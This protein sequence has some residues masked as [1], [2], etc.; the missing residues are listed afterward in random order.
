MK[1]YSTKLTVQKN[2]KEV[3]R[4]LKSLLL[5]Y[6]NDYQ[7]KIV[8]F[9]FYMFKKQFWQA[10]VDNKN[11]GRY[12]HGKIENDIIDIYRQGS[13]YK[14]HF[15]IK[16]TIKEI[17][18][19]SEVSLSYHIDRFDQ[20]VFILITIISV[21]FYLNVGSYLSL[22]FPLIIVISYIFGTY[23]SIVRI[24]KCLGLYKRDTL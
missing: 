22:I 8:V 19:V 24:K 3:F 15:E 10:L 18:E 23:L 9:P 4:A 6:D 12:Y 5:I 21:V 7:N 14:P 13:R 2:K 20:F 17:A 16:G 11:K 1:Y